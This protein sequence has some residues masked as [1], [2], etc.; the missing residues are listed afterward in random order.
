MEMVS[1]ENFVPTNKRTLPIT[2]PLL[3]KTTLDNYLKFYF[4]YGEDSL[5][6][7]QYELYLAVY[8]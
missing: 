5:T 6:N 3:R 2:A 1:V 7:K 8:I 4:L